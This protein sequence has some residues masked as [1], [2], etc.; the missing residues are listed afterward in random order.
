MKRK[1]RGTAENT[2]ALSAGICYILLSVFVELMRLK[3]G[4]F[5][6]AKPK[7]ATRKCD[8]FKSLEKASAEFDLSLTPEQRLDSAQLLK[9]QYYSIKHLKHKKMDKKI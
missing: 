4:L 5:G 8:S 7:F 1:K 9:E 3:R 6:M 2:V